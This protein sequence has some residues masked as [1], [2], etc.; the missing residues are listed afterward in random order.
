MTVGFSG[1]EDVGGFG[2]RIADGDI[3]LAA[4]LL[5]ILRVQV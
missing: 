1:L 3:D 2:L 5:R 4:I